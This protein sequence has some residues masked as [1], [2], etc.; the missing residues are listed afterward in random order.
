MIIAV[1]PQIKSIMDYC[2]NNI[3]EEGRERRDDLIG[4]QEF[5]NIAD[6]VFCKNDD[7][8]DYKI[9]ECVTSTELTENFAK[10]GS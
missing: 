7:I 1:C 8:Y 3:L 10:E 4:N 5:D 6:L 9:A 2:N